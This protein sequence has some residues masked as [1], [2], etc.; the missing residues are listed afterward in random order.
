MNKIDR[1]K[2]YVLVLDIE[3]ANKDCDPLAY[4]IGFAVVDKKGNIYEEYSYMVAEMFFDYFDDAIMQTAYYAAKLPQY[5]QDYRNRKRL[6]TSIYSIRKVVR[7]VMERYNITEVY[8]YNASFDN[9][10]L[11]NTMRYL[12]ASR[13]RWFFPYG[14]TIHCIW[15]MATQVICTQKSYMR[16]CRENGYYSEKGNMTTN[17]ETVYKYMTQNTE[18]AE[19]HTGL[20]DVRIEAAILAKCFAQHKKMSTNIKRNCWMIPQKQFKAMMKG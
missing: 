2:K 8:A 3:T 15:H 4:D 5:W 14:T 11:L 12:T 13:C 9:G 1:R 7:E 16:F 17:A 19:E 18:F 20:E 6:M 10:G